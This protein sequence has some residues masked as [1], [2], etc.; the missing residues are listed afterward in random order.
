MKRLV[1]LFE[2][3]LE[4]TAEE[5]ME[6]EKERSGLVQSL[7]ALRMESLLLSPLTTNFQ[8]LASSARVSS[9]FGYPVE[10]KTEEEQEH[11]PVAVV[12]L[13]EKTVKH[14]ELFGI[15]RRAC[16]EMLARAVT[17]LRRSQAAANAAPDFGL[18]SRV[19]SAEGTRPAAGAPRELDHG[20]F[21]TPEA[22][23]RR[24]VSMDGSS[25]SASATAQSGAASSSAGPS[26]RSAASGANGQRTRRTFSSPVLGHKARRAGAAMAHS[27]QELEEM[28]AS[29]VDAERPAAASSASRCDAAVVEAASRL[30]AEALE[31]AFKRNVP[32]AMDIVE[33]V[34]SV[35]DGLEGPETQSYRVNGQPARAETRPACVAPSTVAAREGGVMQK[36]LPCLPP[37]GFM[38]GLRPSN[39]R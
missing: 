13:P 34:G 32:G 1:L 26:P 4:R 35:L 33:R 23:Q 20:A 19:V 12:A 30:L 2:A 28:A 8:S 29:S 5:K 21:V 37:L 27:V 3:E 15:N 31:G 24:A 36:L 6:L 14:D 11:L 17:P 18:G 39:A 38:T 16:R 25:C 22:L 9:V 7:D 10:E